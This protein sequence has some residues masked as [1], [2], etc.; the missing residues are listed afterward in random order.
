MREQVGRQFYYWQIHWLQFKET[1]E[2]MT[3]LFTLYTLVLNHR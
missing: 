2:K 1:Y 3:V